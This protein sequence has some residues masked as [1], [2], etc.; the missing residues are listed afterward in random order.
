LRPL[1][2]PVDRNLTAR[3][4]SSAKPAGYRYFRHL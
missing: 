4:S 1:K 3:N 2:S